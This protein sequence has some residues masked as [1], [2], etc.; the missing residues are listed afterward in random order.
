M[1]VPEVLQ[2]LPTMP[3]MNLLT[4]APELD[5]KLIEETVR[6]GSKGDTEYYKDLLDRVQNLEA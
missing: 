1:E 5:S 2:T 3:P 4:P 6:P